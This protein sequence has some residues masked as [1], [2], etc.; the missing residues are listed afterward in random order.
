MR[1]K[2]KALPANPSGDQTTAGR[3]SNRSSGDPTIV[4]Q[5]SSQRDTSSD[6]SIAA[7]SLT[8]PRSAGDETV[9]TGSVSA[10][11]KPTE[12]TSGLIST[13]R[14]TAIRS[15]RVPREDELDAMGLSQEK[16]PRSDCLVPRTGG[17]WAGRLRR[18]R[19]H[20]SA[21]DV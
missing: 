9:S 18:S 5:P 16:Q 3:P 1:S 2:K 12:S 15:D 17:K 8:E 19:H 21:E 11:D 7:D 14:E 4:A 10:D 6:V 20:K 13:E